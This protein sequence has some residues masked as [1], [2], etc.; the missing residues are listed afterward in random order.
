MTPIHRRPGFVAAAVIIFLS[1]A[2]LARVASSSRNELV[3]AN[4]HRHGGEIPL[5]IEHYRRAIR[6][7]YPMNPHSAK[8]VG[9]LQSIGRELERS[10][11]REGALLAWRSL[12]GALAATRVL[13]LGE[14]PA[15]EDANAEIAR[16][17]AMDRNA[18]L[19]RG[20]S[21][22]Q[23]A[24]D[25]LRLLAVD[26]S[27]NPWWATLLI[28]GMGIWTGALF[29]LARRGFDPEGRF[30]WASAK[31]PFWGALVGLVSFCLGLLFA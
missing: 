26:G 15:R 21:D 27:P 11:D 28:V 17:L 22:E 31:A 4:A 12:S 13:Y 8:A 30:Q 23:L 19:D 10:G 5:A 14:H 3:A 29:V 2:S 16:L 25:H 24:A 9:A 20:L 7:Q 1:A 6:W 18:E